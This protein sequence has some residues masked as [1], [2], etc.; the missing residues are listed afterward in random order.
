MDTRDQVKDYYGKELSDS[1]DLKTNACCTDFAYPQEIKDILSS[2]H[3]EVMSKY[4]GCGLTLPNSLDNCAILDLGSGSGRDC[5][6]ASKLV[7]ENGLVVGVDMTDEQ[8]D[9]ANRHIDFHTDLF[10]Y[11]KAN[12]SFKKGYIEELDKLELKDS[13]FD[14]I[15]SN[16]VINLST[17]KRKVLADCYNL[18]K[19][20]GEMYFS[21]VYASRRVPKVL[22]DD[23]VLYGE[24]LSGA[25]YYNDFETI[26]KEVGFNAPR[27]VEAA[28]ITIENKDIQDKLEGYEFYSITYRLFKLDD[29]E[30]VSEDYGHKATYNGSLTDAPNKFMF[31]NQNTFETGKERRIDGNTM[32]MLSDS[33][34]K[35]HFDFSGSFESHKGVFSRCASNNP[36][37][38]LHEENAKKGGG[39]C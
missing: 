7:G 15:I 39:C 19:V 14:I 16:C 35:K 8:L 17:D 12:I 3:D 11:K 28:P 10:G 6:I 32:R 34:Y 21:D 38:K 20:G 33:R 2:L 24:C 31:D 25:L 26:A 23:P 18:L 1:K 29:L 5:Y 4:Y 9:V 36:Y 30:L 27:V 37:A 13:S 22:Q